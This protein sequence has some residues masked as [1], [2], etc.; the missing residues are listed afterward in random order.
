MQQ[1]TQSLVLPFASHV[2]ASTS[3]SEA[4]ESA[5]KLFKDLLAES[6]RRFRSVFDRRQSRL[7]P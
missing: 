7:A 3:A 6:E 5:V 2:A 4:E 1:I